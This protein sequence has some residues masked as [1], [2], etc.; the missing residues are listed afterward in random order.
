MTATNFSIAI[1]KLGRRDKDNIYPA[2]RG[3]T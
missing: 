2:A 3:L 1:K